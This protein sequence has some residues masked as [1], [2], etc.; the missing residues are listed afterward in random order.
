MRIALC[1]E[2][3]SGKD[4][5]ASIMCPLIGSAL[6]LAFGDFMKHY[7]Y[8]DNP[9]MEGKPKDREHMI[10]WSQPQVEQDNLIWV[11]MVEEFIKSREENFPFRDDSW[12]ITDLRQPHEEQWC[13]E[14]GFHIV[15]VHAPA[16][17]RE[18]RARALGEKLGI[19]LAYEVSADFHLYND[20]NL[21]EL[22]ESCKRLLTVLEITDKMKSV[23][24]ESN[25]AYAKNS[26]YFN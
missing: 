18:E 23:T 15:R 13:R 16:L 8:K 10:A 7:Y 19:D 22:Q 9:H 14:N 4:T 6:R 21:E 20:G 5:V 17:T 3:R 11:R 12:I 1:G 2:A 24:K 26:N 25:K